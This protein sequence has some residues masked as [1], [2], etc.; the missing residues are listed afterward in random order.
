MLSFATL[1]YLI[2]TFYYYERLPSSKE[3]QAPDYE[4]ISVPLTVHEP[5]EISRK[6]VRGRVIFDAAHGNAF[7]SSEIGSL[8]EGFNG[9]QVDY[10]IAMS[11]EDF[12]KALKSFDS[13]IIISPQTPYS[14]WEVKGLK[15][16]IEKGGKLALFYDPTRRGSI[17]QISTQLD[18]LFN[19][20]YLYNME[21]NAGNY[22]NIFIEEFR[23]SPITIGL[24]KITLFT[25]SSITSESGVAF[26]DDSTTSSLK[27]EGRHSTIALVGD[28]V[29]AVSDQ[30]FLK[31][32]NNR[33]L[34]NGKLV[35]NI[36][37]F[38][39]D[40]KRR[41]VLEDFPFLF[42]DVSISYSNETLVDEALFAKKIFV[43]FGIGS[44]ISNEP[45]DET[46]FIGLVND[47]REE[48]DSLSHLV[49][50]DTIVAGG[51]E[52]S[53]NV[54]AFAYLRD[55][56]LWVIANEEDP[57]NEL[58]TILSNGE[59]SYHQVSEDLAILPFEPTIKEIPPEEGLDNET[60]SNFIPQPLVNG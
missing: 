45:A 2:S 55:R 38:L 3:F 13:I 7:N 20:D 56:K 15:D 22:R 41:Y 26:T 16:F 48:L 18:V 37:T 35:S 10:E 54:T 59:I 32:P 19:P 28:S 46:M 31:Q 60:S 9:L 47:S 43:D 52:L 23:P 51:L 42:R 27:G 58:L 25:A 6:T 44:K 4:S 14:N 24:N 33:I 12:Q 11:G 40:G 1:T 36:A 30:S 17:N 57:I 8:L 5:P 39:G 34:D 53:L 50:N 49:I 21:N 29:L